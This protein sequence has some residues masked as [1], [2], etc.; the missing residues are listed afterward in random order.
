MFSAFVLVFVS[1]IFWNILIYFS[2]WFSWFVL[3]FECG[4]NSIFTLYVQA[5]N[6]D[7]FR[8]TQVKFCQPH[9]VCWFNNGNTTC[10][11]ELPW[12]TAFCSMLD[13]TVAVS[14]SIFMFLVFVRISSIEFL[15]I[16][17]FRFALVIIKIL[18]YRNWQH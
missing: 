7:G 14:N 16:K 11:S 12:S 6:G 9:F 5:E 4:I 3:P 8:T 2:P 10:L 13:R 15:D 18:S 17:S 1:F